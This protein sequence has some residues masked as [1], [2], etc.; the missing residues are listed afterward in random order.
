MIFERKG[1]MLAAINL[2]GDDIVAIVVILAVFL[3]GIIFSFKFGKY[4][5]EIGI[6]EQEIPKWLNTTEKEFE[7]KVRAI[8]ADELKRDR[9]AMQAKDL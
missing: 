7:D 2:S 9:D 3:P 1:K 8:V 6:K 4:K 5:T